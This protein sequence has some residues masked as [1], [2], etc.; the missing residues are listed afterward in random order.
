MNRLFVAA[1]LVAFATPLAAQAPTGQVQSTSAIKV[2]VTAKPSLANAAKI[3]ADSAYAIAISR[4]KGGEVSSAKLETIDGRLDYR[5]QVLH[6]NKRATEVV[7]DAM[8]GRVLD[9]KQHGGLK[10]AE[11]HHVENN[12]M[13]KA[14]NDSAAKHP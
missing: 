8:N 11:V 10:A 3:S 4:V 1:V 2:Q 13:V 6:G 9:V 14:K 7:V 5:V 12:K